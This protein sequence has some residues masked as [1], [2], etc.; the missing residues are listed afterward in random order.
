MEVITTGRRVDYWEFYRMAKDIIDTSVKRGAYINER[1]SIHM[2][3]LASYYGKVPGS[4][5][6]NSSKISEMERSLPEIVLANFHQLI[7][8]YQN[9]ITW[10]TSGLNEPNR[11]TRWEKFRVSVL[12]ISAVHNNMRQVRDEVSS[13]AGGNKYGWANY[14]FCDFDDNGAVKRLHVEVRAMDGLLSPSAVS[15]CACMYYALFI[16]AV[17]L[18]RYGIMSVGDDAWKKQADTVK[19]AIMNNKS[20]Y[21]DGDKYGRFSDTS[22]LH[23]YTDILVA[24]SFELISQLKHI[25]APV[26]PAYDVLEKLAESPCSI[27]RC[28]GLEWEQIEDQLVV[29]LTEEGKFEYEI[30][31]IIDTR[32]VSKVEN[33]QA[34]MDQ[35]A[36][37]LQNNKDLGLTNES[38]EEISDKV[39]MHV[40]DKQSNGEMIWSEK[41]GSMITI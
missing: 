21:K 35:V 39:A 28:D 4:G 40:E 17:E 1:C 29:K 34:W 16:K 9:A 31:K 41:I 22:K 10:M 25:L 7:R 6:S 27:R 37:N 38:L 23:K 5:G 26:G 13:H 19:N 3:G 36:E 8:R 20:D 18:S 12:G 11:L 32:G 14:K 24:E 30:T 2:H 15:A 33:I